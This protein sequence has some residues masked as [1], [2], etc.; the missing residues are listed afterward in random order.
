MGWYKD[1]NAIL[2]QE[3]ETWLAYLYGQQLENIPHLTRSRR[4]FKGMF[5]RFCAHGLF[6][7]RHLVFRQPNA[8]KARADYLVFAGSA[9]QMSSLE[10]TTDVL[11][12]KENRVV[13]IGNA[14]LLH[15]ED[16]Q[17]RFIPVGF[18]VVDIAKS[19]VLLLRNG[20]AMYKGL[21][22][23]HPAAIQ[24]YFDKFCSVYTHLV[25]FHR[26]L[27]QTNPNFVITAND[28]NPSN[29]SL[30]AAA[31]Y[32]GIKTVYLQH[33][34]VS[35][36]FPALRV[37]YAFLDGQC[38]LDAYRDC[39]KNQPETHRKAP[40]PKVLLTGQKKHLARTDS[41]QTKTIGIA[42]NALD[43]ATAAIEFVKELV[44]AGQE[45]RV[46]WHPGQSERDIQ[47]YMRVFGDIPQV[48]LSNPKT[49]PVS[50]FMAQTRWL[51]AG[52]SSIHLEAALAGVTPIYFELTPPDTTDYYGYVRHGL[53]KP[54]NSPDDILK[55]VKAGDDAEGPDFKA[56]R[57]YSA[58][59]LTDWDGREG[60]LVAECL[61]RV[62]RGD[63]LPVEIVEIQTSQL[64]KLLSLQTHE[65]P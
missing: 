24:S 6:L 64:R 16:Q 63:V 3:P 1:I 22:K 23:K 2:E 40:L 49:E 35:S 59:Y 38:A 4:R 34:S 10:G 45:L 44:K 43:N 27:R 42:L 9:N 20:P 62:F 50:D 15:T 19:L 29:R 37:N 5:L 33:A 12:E 17:A 28:H 39:E 21:Q 61:L 53:A 46:R 54:A 52:N 18:T 32:L 30:L 57:Y 58:T 55:M 56:V 48:A 41:N 26:I 8:L 51:V 31:H 7:V 47:H 36:L 13:E 65:A 14:K 11:K 25:Y 60:E